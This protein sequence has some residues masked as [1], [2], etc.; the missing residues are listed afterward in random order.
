MP[1][2]KTLLHAVQCDAANVCQREICSPF[3]CCLRA[4][5]GAVALKI[6]NPPFPTAPAQGNKDGMKKT[7]NNSW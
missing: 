5:L 6:K 1:L 4:H 3:S 7:L 2:L